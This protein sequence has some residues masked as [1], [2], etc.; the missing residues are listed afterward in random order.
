MSQSYY[1]PRLTIYVVWHPEYEQ[2]QK[3]ANYLYSW[4]SRDVKNPVSRR[5]GIPIFFRNMNDAK[6]GAPLP[7]PFDNARHTAVVALVDDHF[8]ASDSWDTYLGS[9]WEKT[10]SPTSP[11]R[12]FPVSISPYSFNLYSGVPEAN[13]IRLHDLKEGRRPAVLA[14]S[15]THELCRLLLGQERA[16]AS[17]E[18]GVSFAPVKLFLS[19]AKRD[20]L[21][22]AE[23]F[24]DYLHRKTA[25]KSFF[26]AN[27]IAPG[28]S[29]AEEIRAQIQDA[30]VLAIQTDAYS[31][32]EWC[33]R[34]ILMAKQMQRPLVVVNALRE[35][36]ERS[37]PYLGNAATIRWKLD[38]LQNDPELYDQAIESALDLMLY[39]VL[40][41]T[42]LRQHFKDLCHLFELPEQVEW[43]S[44]PPE[45]LTLLHL[46]RTMPEE[47][48]K[49][50][51]YPDPPIGPEEM[52]V[53]SA[54]TPNFTFITPMFLRR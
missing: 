3:F 26:D 36:E 11:H 8:V 44:R 31:S 9:L 20:G 4:L 51:L 14:R 46:K 37:F 22:I 1:K 35:N 43:S 16:S 12:L 5:I 50:L 25:L 33:R 24:R 45:L 2:G 32:R 7:I 53:L 54:L 23:H 15:L 40:K 27:D 13:F 21:A 18:T 42:Y 29:F 39:E 6:S 17:S 19:H 41:D 49:M 30:A 52:E 10:Q 34:E 48:S 28:Y 47:E 38:Q